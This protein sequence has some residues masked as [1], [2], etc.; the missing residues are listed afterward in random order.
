MSH[1]SQR[2]RT[3]LGLTTAVA[4]ALSGATA[5]GGA[6]SGA[7]SVADQAVGQVIGAPA[8]RTA[9]AS[10][11]DGGYIVLMAQDPVASY[12]GGLPGLPATKPADGST[13]KLDVAA[14]AAT[15]YAQHLTAEQDSTL[16]RVGLPT[17]KVHTRY[18]TAL[19]GFAGT[20]TGHEAAALAADP[21][22]LAVVPDEIRQLD[23][24][25]SPDVLG[26][27]GEGGV[28]ERLA[29]AGADPTE[30]GKGVVVGIVDSGI[31]PTNPSFADTG[32]Q[33][34]PADWKGAC[35]TA[36]EETFPADSC[37]DKLIGAK[38]FV[39]GFGS[40]RL[41]PDESL[42]PYDAG[43]HGTH[44]ASTAAGN[45]GVTATVD[46]VVRGEISGM[47][48]GA[49]VAAYKAC[50]EGVT[51][52]G[53]S[54]IDTVAAIDAAVADGVDVINY[55]I[56]GSQTDIMDPVELAFMNAAS[57]GVF[58]AA[59]SGNSGPTPS[60]TAHASPWITTVAASTHAVYE[61]TL[62]TGDGERYIGSS[63][64]RP[65]EA[66]TPMAYAKDLAAAGADPAKAALCIKDTLD[67]ALTEGKLVVC[68]RGENDRAEKSFVVEAAGGAG[69]VLVNVTEGQ[70]LNA[71][72]HATPAVHL[73][74][75]ARESVV[76]YASTEGATGRILDTNEGSTTQ[77]PLV[78][79]F[80]SRGPSL[81]AESDLLK[82]DISAPGVDVL[83]AYSPNRRGEDFAYSSGTSMSSP[84]IAGLAALVKQ[85]RPE[86]SPMQIK[87]AMMTTAADHAEA[88]SPFAEGSG[89]VDPTRM[90]TPGLTFDSDR[91]D[92]FDF[93]AGQGVV[94]SDTGNP[95]SDTPIDASDLN[96]PSLAIGQLFGEQTVQRTLTAVDGGGT[97]T[98]S[99]ESPG[100]LDVS[101]SPA[102]FTVAD[103]QAQDVEI[104]LT[105]GTAPA[106]QWAS[107]HIVWTSTDGQTV[108]MP[109]VAQPGV[110][111]APDLIEGHTTDE[112]LDL[113]VLSGVDGTLETRVR[114]LIRVD[115][116]TGEA[117]EQAFFDGTDTRLTAHNLDYPRG[118]P[119]VR[120]EARTVGDVEADL[121][122]YVLSS[123]SSFPVA[124]SIS[125]GKGAEIFEGSI[126][127][128]APEHRIY[129]VAKGTSDTM[130][131]YTLRVTFPT[132]Q[133]TG[134]LG[135]DPSSAAV[136]DGETHVFTGTVDT[137]G[138]SSYNGFVDVLYDGRV[139]DTTAIRLHNGEKAPT[140][141]EDPVDPV[142]PIDPEDPVDPVDPVQPEVCEDEH[143]AD[144]APGTVY[145]SAVRWMQC[146][147]IAGGYDDG[148]FGKRKQI[149]RGESTAF[150]YRALT[151]RSFTSD[152]VLFP[153][154][155][156]D[157]TFYTPITWA[158]ENGIVGGYADG[159]FRPNRE[160]TRG[161]FAS[162]LYRTVDPGTRVAA[163]PQF[164]DM[165]PGDT[166]YAAVQWL[167]VSGLA[168]GY[169]DGDFKPGRNI[170]R[171][172]VAALMHRH[173]TLDD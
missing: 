13:A 96:V 78:A 93:L 65:L 98:A 124:R 147:G 21:K 34:A 151:D 46:G 143:F 85:G 127:S 9:P 57:A 108:R 146:A 157:R 74:A 128:S 32:H 49:H 94:Y 158:G 163:V 29:G 95:V 170:T 82:P 121:D 110:A 40:F 66:D 166:H 83:A 138:E 30:V 48:P 37:T 97:W 164:E 75:S 86:F 73:P 80:S 91:D 87:S 2:R 115:E 17:D 25:S 111:D 15:K 45:H 70:G 156:T 28:W 54:T 10:F 152:Q 44:T 55:S 67:P 77:T 136:T 59:S 159:T 167:A 61:Q 145:F 131:P 31:I 155:P 7:P 142:D 171:G 79:S 99:V 130:V 140:D 41:A 62:V 129:V 113:P 134:V 109:V 119:T 106:G 52:G 23:T 35:E 125:Y 3:A 22:V 68:D 20:F 92:W 150:I 161:E 56:S 72:V 60:T 162:I 141:P 69:V 58:V 84:H 16:R 1:P 137:D 144:N 139:V 172:E 118:Y 47:A 39:N 11:E 18:T 116:S 168:G 149:S 165:K 24:V 53:C 6:P 122:I 36:D 27:R 33:A 81:A 12:T 63:I 169:A 76:A 8:E 102:T 71:D 42:S 43:G 117:P 154:V 160:I 5:A 104:S 133:D 132:E 103:A 50:W 51:S 107:A 90:M 148:T 89:F 126:I 101:V 123:R 112:T 64:M 135:F 88:T 26:L 120:I 14:P 105:P 114:G 100:G 38:Y 4:L 19:N 173:H 153:D